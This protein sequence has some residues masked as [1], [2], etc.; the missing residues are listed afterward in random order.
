MEPWT[1]K[2]H[3]NEEK[4]KDE[5]CVMTFLNYLTIYVAG[6]FLVICC[7]VGNEVHIDVHFQS[8]S[9]SCSPI[10]IILADYLVTKRF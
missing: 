5:A 8:F 3:D 4:S 10:L 1:E 9:Y 7:F 2:E 6:H